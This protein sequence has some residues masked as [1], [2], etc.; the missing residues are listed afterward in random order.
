M[1][2]SSLMFPLLLVL[3]AVPLFLS[4]RKQKRAVAEQQAL[5]NSLEPGDRVMTTSGLYA[6]VAGVNDD[7]N[8]IEL[9]IA[10]GVITTWL[11]QAIREKVVVDT[12]TDA[13]V[14]DVEDVEDVVDETADAERAQQESKK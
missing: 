12:E 8:T 9:E 5:L 14:D 13:V 6:T 2:L 3:L 10:D 11:R 4:A 7:D 1:D